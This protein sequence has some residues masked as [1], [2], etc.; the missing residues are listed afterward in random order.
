MSW[1]CS[2]SSQATS[3]NICLV[4]SLDVTLRRYLIYTIYC[5]WTTEWFTIHYINYCN[6]T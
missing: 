2:Y 1:D 3:W 6:T 4:K 5:K